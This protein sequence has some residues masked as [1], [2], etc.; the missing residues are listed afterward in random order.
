MTKTYS[1]H[2]GRKISFY[3][4]FSPFSKTMTSPYWKKENLLFSIFFLLQRLRA[5]KRRIHHTFWSSHSK[6][7]LLTF[8][9]LDFLPFFLSIRTIFQSESVF[10][11]GKMGNSSSWGDMICA[12]CAQALKVLKRGNMRRNDS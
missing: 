4:F 8:I 9:Y 6:P 1:L 12:A 5:K 2:K 10:L 3:F 11:R 7:D